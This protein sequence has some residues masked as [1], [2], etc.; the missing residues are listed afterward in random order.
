MTGEINYIKKYNLTLQDVYDLRK[1]ME[2]LNKPNLEILEE[3]ILS[4]NSM[5][6]I[7]DQLKKG[8]SQQNHETMIEEE[9]EYMEKYNLT[10]QDIKQLRSILKDMK[11]NVFNE[12]KEYN[13]SEN[14]I[15]HGMDFFTD[16]L[17][18]KESAEE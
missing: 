18:K 7:I 13:L 6:F 11:N 9:I 14:A 16:E 12:D 8:F 2:E 5:N 3:C 15:K 4:I 1:F 10:L 17:N